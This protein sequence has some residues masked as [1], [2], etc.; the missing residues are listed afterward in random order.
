M[1][2]IIFGR[3]NAGELGEDYI[4]DNRF[5]FKYNCRDYSFSDPFVKKFIK[6][7]DKADVIV[8]GALKDE[9][10]YYI[11]VQELSTGCKTLCCL[12][13][14]GEYYM[15]YGTMLGNNCVPYLMEIAR[16]KDISILLE[17]YM[18]IPTKYFNEGIV[19]VN[20]KVVSEEDYDDLY[21]AWCEEETRIAEEEESEEIDYSLCRE[22][23]RAEDE[24][25]VDILWCDEEGVEYD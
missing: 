8:E 13:F 19:Y 2:N 11:S 10:G 22:G 17:H 18:D 21:S 12:Y 6:D 16:N 24:N 9:A 5:Y 4:L 20:N 1:L 23:A 7:I 3:R 25:D 15:F 14:D